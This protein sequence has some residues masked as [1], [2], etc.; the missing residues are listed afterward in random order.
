MLVHRLAIVGGDG[1]QIPFSHRKMLVAFN[2]EIYNWRELR[3]QLEYDWKTDCDVEVLAEAWHRWGPHGALDKIDGQFA[4]AIADQ[5]T[6]TLFLARDRAGEK[7]LYWGWGDD[8]DVFLAASE[9]KAL[10]CYLEEEEFCRELELYEYDCRQDTP[11]AGIYSFPPGH[12]TGISSVRGVSKIFPI[13]YW[14][15]PE[16]CSIKSDHRLID[17]VESAVRD[18]IPKDIPWTILVSGG[19]DSAI[20]QRIAK[21]PVVY[22]IKF[23]YPGFDDTP[24][25]K[26]AANGAD[27]RV[28]TFTKEDA[29]EALPAIAWHLD[30]PATWTALAQWFIAKKIKEDGFKVVFSGEGADEV[31]GGYTRYLLLNRIEEVFGEAVLGTTYRPLTEHVIGTGSE[32]LAKIYYRGEHDSGLGNVRSDMASFLHECDGDLIEAARRFEWHYTMQVLLRQTDR[33]FM[34]HGIELR[35]PYLARDLV[36]YGYGAGRPVIDPNGFT[37]PDLRTIASYLGIPRSITHNK[38]KRGFAVPWNLWHQGVSQDR[39]QWGRAH[40][41]Q[42]MRE[43]WR[44]VFFHTK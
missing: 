22:T 1:V 13:P 42:T 3:K 5:E 36:E 39:G 31:F 30:T 20:L 2:G 10:D 35:C 19:I 24:A 14:S 6:G 15:V 28:V 41:A 44:R 29:L 12:H 26:I 17:R 23:D 21:A 4:F 25:A 16:P 33:M 8:P 40:F 38:A 34:A 37:K 9:I 7:S 43:T 32:I 27:L 18:R 11:F